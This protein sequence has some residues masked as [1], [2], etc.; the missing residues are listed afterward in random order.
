MNASKQC[1]KY[2]LYLVNNF[3]ERLATIS[4]DNIEVVSFLLAGAICFSE[5]KH[6]NKITQS[7][8]KFIVTNIFDLLV[9]NKSIRKN[10]NQLEIVNSAVERYRQLTHVQLGGYQTRST[11]NTCGISSESS[12]EQ[13]EA[14]LEP[15]VITQVRRYFKELKSLVI[16][17]LVRLFKFG[18]GK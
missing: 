6:N 18:G 11:G 10:C 8:L 7:E 4:K 14:L 17:R 5:D 1:N 12:L 9:Y 15:Q 3:N 2:Q 16:N 13:G